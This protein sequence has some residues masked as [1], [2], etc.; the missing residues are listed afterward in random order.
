MWDRQVPAL[1]ARRRLVRF[2]HRGHGHSPAPPGPYS[3]DDLGGDVLALLDR[4]EIPR[5]SYCGLSL[6]G[7]IGIW[8][9]AHAPERIERL[10]LI[11][12]AAHAPP[13]SDY[14]ERG[15][16]VRAA[17]TPEVVADAVLARW[18]TPAFARGHPDVVARHRAMIAAVPAEGYAGCCEAIAALDLRDDLPQIRARTLVIAAANDLALPPEYGRAIAEAIPDARLEVLDPAAHLASVERAATVTELIADHL[19]EP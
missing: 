16:R 14:A 17:G 11:C 1:A 2:D 6:G 12:T 7:M 10:V 4:L 5:A 9:A 18:F 19:E 3:I 13:G 15:E 8:L